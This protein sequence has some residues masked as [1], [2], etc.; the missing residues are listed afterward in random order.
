MRKAGLTIVSVWLLSAACSSPPGVLDQP[1]SGGFIDTEEPESYGRTGLYTYMD[2]GA[3]LY[4]EYGFSNL[5]VRRYARGKDRYIIELYEMR[6]PEAASAIYTYSR[7]HGKEA[8]LL[9]G[10][11]GSIT[12]SEILLARGA[13]YL[14]CRDEDPMARNRVHLLELARQIAERLSGDCGVAGRLFVRLPAERRVP[15]SEV[16]LS[17]PIALNVRPWL[18]SLGRAG[19]QRGWLATYKYPVGQIEALLAEYNSPKAA[20][21]A[22]AALKEANED[23]VYTDR[24]DEIVAVTRAPG[25]PRDDVASLASSLLSPPEWR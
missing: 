11:V 25:V 21:Q 1:L 18:L 24:L 6:D 9:P 13:S 17:G 22:T 16:V 12:D 8:E 23:G 5:S 14:V 10:C 2:G 15:G 20:E 19:F 4:I 3:D 7:R